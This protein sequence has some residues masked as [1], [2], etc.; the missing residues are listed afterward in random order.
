VLRSS[1]GEEE[2]AAAMLPTDDTATLADDAW[3]LTDG[4]TEP[5]MLEADETTLDDSDALLS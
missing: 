4:T 5:R 3:L 1:G 2:L